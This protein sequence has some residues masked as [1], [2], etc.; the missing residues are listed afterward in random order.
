MNKTGSLEELE[1]LTAAIR[2]CA[3]VLQQ[4]DDRLHQDAGVTAAMRQV[5][6]FL[7]SEGPSTVPDIARARGV[8]RQNIQVLVDALVVRDMVATRANPAHRRSSLVVLTRSGAQ[9]YRAMR[10]R[11]QRFLKGLAADRS[12]S[13]IRAA[14]RAVARLSGD[15]EAA[16]QDI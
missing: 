10:R 16:S 3:D 4:A 6:E 13:S 12:V 8:S 1:A 11:E 14:R 9:T 15:L 7:R 5:M 2:T